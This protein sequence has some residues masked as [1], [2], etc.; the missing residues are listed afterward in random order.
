MPIFAIIQPVPHFGDTSAIDTELRGAG[1]WANAIRYDPL[2]RL[3]EFC[4]G[5]ALALLYRLLPMGSRLWTHGARFYI[6]AIAVILLVLGYADRIPYPLVHNGLLAP[7]YALM[8]FGFALE[9]G[10]LV[11]F[12]SMPA[13]VFLGG[14]SYSM[15]ILHAPVYAWMSVGFIRIL[16]LAPHGLFWLICYLTA[17]VGF[18]AVFFRTVEEP[19]HRWLRTKLNAWAENPRREVP[20]PHS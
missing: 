8:I 7:A 15:Y 4:M 11:R 17:V 3:P 13:M 12:L 10:V 18:S 19:T 1:A 2:L 5:V 20:V 14:A 16:H 6:P 9:G